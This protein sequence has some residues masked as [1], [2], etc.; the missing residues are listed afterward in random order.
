MSVGDQR[1]DGSGGRE[2]GAPSAE[3]ARLVRSWRERL[4]P[5]EIPGL[6]VGS[7]RRKKTR[8]S[9][10]DIARLVGASSVWYGKLER[11]ELLNY[12]DDFIDR[13]AISLRLNDDERMT[14]YLY[15]VGREPVPRQRSSSFVVT[16]VI[17]KIV[18]EQPWPAYVSD[19]SWD[20]VTYNDHVK[21][22][23][24]WIEW[25]NNVMR[26]VFTYP[27][28]RQQLYNWDTDWAPLMLAQMRVARAREPENERLANLVE[29]ILRVNDDAK[30][31]WESEPAVYVHPDGDRRQF[32]LPYHQEVITVEIV[33]LAPL[34]ATN[35][36]VMMLIPR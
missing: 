17:E 34:R 15:S 9:Q 10:E 2:E 30:R 21:K 7:S 26:W 35:V 20:V 32:Y 14:L 22:W 31:M 16:E 19:E 13:V 11:G 4:D 28:A 1:A 18:Q 23:F 25:E 5:R 27:E 36:R 33:A 24:P 12:S 8:V 3:L 29:E 6:T